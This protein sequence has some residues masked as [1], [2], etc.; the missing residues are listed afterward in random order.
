MA[1]SQLRLKGRAD[2]CTDQDLEGIVNKVLEELNELGD[3][4]N[5]KW[6]N[7]AKSLE[8]DIT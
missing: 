1:M 6:I 2:A 5:D 7:I 4:L 8:I 3:D